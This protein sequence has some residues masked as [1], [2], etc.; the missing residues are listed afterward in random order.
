[1]NIYLTSVFIAQIVEIHL[2]GLVNDNSLDSLVTHGLDG[3]LE[4][5]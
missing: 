3:G 4:P 1:M 2:K 5:D